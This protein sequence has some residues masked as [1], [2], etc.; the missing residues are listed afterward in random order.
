MFVD[1][2]NIKTRKLV[3]VNSEHI[4]SIWTANDHSGY[5][6]TTR[7]R[8]VNGEEYEKPISKDLFLQQISNGK[9]FINET[10]WC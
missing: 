9:E 5:W 3:T 8:D 10:S 1:L 7:V 6:E 4:V 2:I